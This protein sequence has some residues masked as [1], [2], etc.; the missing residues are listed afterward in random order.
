[1]F[2]DL[3][4]AYLGELKIKNG[5]GIVAIVTVS[6]VIRHDGHSGAHFAVKRPTEYDRFDPDR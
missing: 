3:K 2:P 4:V 5:S 6:T 1:M